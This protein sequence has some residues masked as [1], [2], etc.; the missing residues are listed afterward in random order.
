MTHSVRKSWCACTTRSWGYLVIDNTALGPGKGGIRMTPHVTEEE[1]FRLARTMTWKNSLA[2]IPFGGAKGGIVWPSSAPSAVDLLRRGTQAMEGKNG[3]T[4]EKKKAF[5]QSFARTIGGLTPKKYIAGPD[6]ATGEE[7]MRQFVEA[8]GNPRSA[9]GKP[10]SLCAKDGTHCGL[11][12]ELG[13]TGFGVSIATRVALELL[14]RNI[15]GTTVAIHGFGNVATFAFKYLT[16]WGVKVVALADSRMAIHDPKGLN[17]DLVLS[18]IKEGKRLE[19]YPSEAHISA[20]D[21][22]SVPADVLIPASV[23]DV[24]TDANKAKIHAKLIVEGGNIVMSEKIENEFAESGIVV[25]PDFVANA[26]GVISSYAEYRGYSPEKM[27][28]LVE[29]KISKS[30]MKVLKRSLRIKRSPREVAME[31]ARER[32]E[33]AMAHAKKTG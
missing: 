7:E 19:H 21:F 25:I 3:G 29:A 8:T 9:T 10:A 16:E 17:R 6:V 18:L 4:P 26:G 22:W 23:T 13:S 32:V 14:V 28:K 2:G 15:K 27:F 20:E 30:T 1:V 33:K 11:P 24:I 5:M 31:L 12:H